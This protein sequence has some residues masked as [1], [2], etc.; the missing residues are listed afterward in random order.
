MVAK[1]S[2]VRLSYGT[3]GLSP[4]LILEMKQKKRNIYHDDIIVAGRENQSFFLVWFHLGT[5][6][7]FSDQLVATNENEG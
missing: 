5:P 1:S 7:M 2:E 6:L 3:F 4:S